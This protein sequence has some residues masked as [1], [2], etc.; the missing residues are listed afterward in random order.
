MLERLSGCKFKVYVN[1]KDE[2]TDFNGIYDDK[3][4]HLTYNHGGHMVEN[5]D[6]SKE[7]VFE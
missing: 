4:I 1:A 2:V 3:H 6:G 5:R 7:C